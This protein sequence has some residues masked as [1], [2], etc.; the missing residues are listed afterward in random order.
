VSSRHRLA[1]RARNR[2][3]LC[4]GEHLIRR[5]RHIVQNRPLR[6]VGWPTFH[7]RPPGTSVVQRLGSSI[8]SSHGGTASILDRPLMGA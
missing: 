7:S 4:F 1:D 2:Y 5:N 3:A 8:G 6:S